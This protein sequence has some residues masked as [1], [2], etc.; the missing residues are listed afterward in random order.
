MNR[1]FFSNT[2]GIILV[3]L[4]MNGCSPVGTAVSLYE[5]LGGMGQV[6]KLAGGMMNSLASNPDMLSLLS[7][8][9]TG[10]ATG[11]LA[12]QLC[13]ALGGGCSA[14]FSAN[15]IADAAGKLSPAQT[16][17][18]TESFDS[19]LKTVS[20]SPEL[21]SPITESLGSQLGGIV[22]ALL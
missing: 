1:R 2:L 19:A 15:Q 3:A 6:T 12:D 17:A 10:A 11:K 14:P 4:A 9:D 22:G 21:V 5:Q 8:V 20:D 18:V 13:S 16:E 7:N